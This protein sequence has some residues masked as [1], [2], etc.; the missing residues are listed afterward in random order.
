MGAGRV[1][2]RTRDM[3]ARNARGGEDC[4][5]RSA[6][7]EGGTTGHRRATMRP[8]IFDVGVIA[9]AR[10]M[11]RAKAGTEHPGQSATR[12]AVSRRV[13]PPG[14]TSGAASW[15]SH[16]R[17]AAQRRLS[18]AVTTSP[19]M[20]AERQRLW[21]PRGGERRRERAVR[22]Q[23]RVSDQAHRFEC[24]RCQVAWRHYA[25][26]TF[27][28]PVLAAPPNS[29]ASTCLSQSMFS[30]TGRRICSITYPS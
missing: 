11:D 22:N 12:L 27:V 13:A 18:E 21:P 15:A 25:K 4:G 3:I 7:G 20:A 26:R 24:C 5:R 28:S 10:S 29:S 6:R 2:Q 30:A 19:R 23:S 17:F 9:R 16:P 1:R 8:H 14:S